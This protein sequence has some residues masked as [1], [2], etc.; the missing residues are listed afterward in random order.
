[1]IPEPIVQMIDTTAEDPVD[2]LQLQLQL[3]AQAQVE[4]Q[5]QVDAPREDTA[6]DSPQD[7]VQAP[8]I[9]NQV[10]REMLQDPNVDK[11]VQGEIIPYPPELPNIVVDSTVDVMGQEPQFLDNFMDMLDGIFDQAPIEDAAPDEHDG[12]QDPPVGQDRPKKPKRVKHKLK[13]YDGAGVGLKGLPKIE[14]DGSVP[15]AEL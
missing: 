7:I 13:P 4:A 6:F 11:E 14:S 5:T 1:M 15:L 12:S 8:I 2:K 9:H 10:V 3:Q